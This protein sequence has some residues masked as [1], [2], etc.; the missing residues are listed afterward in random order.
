MIG[1][2]VKTGPNFCYI[3]KKYGFYML[4]FAFFIIEGIFEQMANKRGGCGD[5]C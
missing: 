3:I 5:G 1:Y 2:D 4:H